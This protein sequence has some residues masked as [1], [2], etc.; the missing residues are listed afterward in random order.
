MSAEAQPV[1]L[2]D[3][4]VFRTQAGFEAALGNPGRARTFLPQRSKTGESFPIQRNVSKTVYHNSTSDVKIH[5]EVKINGS[6]V[7]SSSTT[8]SSPSPAPSP[9][10]ESENTQPA[11]SK[12]AKASP[13]ATRDHLERLGHAS[14]HPNGSPLISPLADMYKTAVDHRVTGYKPEEYLASYN[15]KRAEFRAGLKK[16]LDEA[17][18]YCGDEGAGNCKE[19]YIRDLLHNEINIKGDIKEELRQS[20]ASNLNNNDLWKRY[21]HKLV[22]RGS[23]FDKFNYNPLANK[24][25]AEVTSEKEVPEWFYRIGTSGIA[26]AA[27]G[28]RIGK[29]LQR[30]ILGFLIGSAAAI[31]GVEIANSY[32]R[33]PCGVCDFIG[34]ARKK[35]TTR[36]EAVDR[37][38]K[39]AQ[40]ALDAAEKDAES[41]FND[42]FFKSAFALQIR[43]EPPPEPRTYSS[44]RSIGSNFCFIA[45]TKITMKD[46]TRKNIEDIETGDEV[47]AYDEVN[48]SVYITPVV[49]LKRTENDLQTLY[50]FTLSDETNFTANATHPIYIQN[51]D[52]YPTAEKIYE[53]F[54]QGEQLFLQNEAGE[55]LTISHID[56][57]EKRV[58][59]YNFHVQGLSER[60]PYDKRGIGHNYYAN[61]ILVHNVR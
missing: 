18:A 61:G 41:D 17:T 55:L 1:S 20:V 52:R 16:F 45:G 28:F 34:D 8:M 21:E 54:H 30:P 58:P 44:Y 47:K 57:E 36:G 14:L 32:K 31:T 12:I 22:G 23:S 59:V 5:I 25:V 9:S 29:S 42:M 39:V 48:K 3:K 33:L 2:L 37:A 51:M 26:G 7:I 53:L 10:P 46:G 60:Y 50:R 43:P 13:S 56:V 40:P 19:V 11:S 35:I 27:L 6:T 24:A 4:K 15:S 38:M 49:E